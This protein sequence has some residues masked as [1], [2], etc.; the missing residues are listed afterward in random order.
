MNGLV[1]SKLGATVGVGVEPPAGVFFG[2]M[3]TIGCEWARQLRAERLMLPA[4]RRQGQAEVGYRKNEVRVF[5]GMAAIGSE[6][7]KPA[8]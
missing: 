1:G 6:K 7:T 8:C 2:G 4:K 5:A 3:L